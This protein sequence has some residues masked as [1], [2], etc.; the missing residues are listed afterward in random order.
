MILDGALDTPDAW[1]DPSLV[2][3]LRRMRE[4]TGKTVI[5]TS[6]DPAEAMRVGDRIA[7]LDNGRLVQAGAPRDLVLQPATGHVA[8]LLSELNPVAFLLAED[9]M[10]PITPA[11]EAAGFAG[12]V[13]TGTR[14]SEVLPTLRR[15]DVVVAERG[16][17]LGKID[18]H[19]LWSLFA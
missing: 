18:A 6:V 7:V 3:A 17:L 14:L 19:R 11:D 4:R 5:L 2:G 9:V 16:R 8:A 12:L 10:S 1:R 15:G 13:Q